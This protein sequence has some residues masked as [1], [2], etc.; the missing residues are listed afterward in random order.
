MATYAHTHNCGEEDFFPLFTSKTST[1]KSEIHH[2]NNNCY[3][4]NYFTSTVT[5]ASLRPVFLLPDLLLQY[6]AL[7]HPIKLSGSAG[8]MV[9]LSSLKV[10]NQ[11]FIPIHSYAVIFSMR[12]AFG[13]NSQVVDIILFENMS[14]TLATYLPYIIRSLIF[15]LHAHDLGFIN[16]AC[17]P[18][19]NRFF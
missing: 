18:P 15:V 5:T 12:P 7:Y 13:T 17:S 4:I 14:F 1:K 11:E 10:R 2:C 3:I 16:Q 9:S 6:K 19:L 8:E